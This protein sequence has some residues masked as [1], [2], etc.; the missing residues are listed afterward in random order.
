MLALQK[1]GVDAREAI[2]VGDSVRRMWRQGRDS[3]WL[4]FMLLMAIEL[5]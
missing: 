3:G 1:L 2:L 5:L 4:L